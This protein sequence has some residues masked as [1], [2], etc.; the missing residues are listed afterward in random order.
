MQEFIGNIDTYL[1]GAPL[2]A[3]AA[4]FAAGLLTSFTPCVYPLI[5]VTVSVIGASSAGSRSRALYLSILYVLGLAA[6]YAGLGAFAALSGQLFG[7]I[8]TG[9]WTFLAVGNI[10]LLFGLAMLDV[11]SL[12]F[13]GLQKLSA[14]RRG[15]KGALSALFMGGVSALIAGPCTTPVL[16]TLLGFVA[17]RQNIVFGIAMLFVFSLGL[18]A[19][20]VLV[21]TFAGALAALPR[22]G[23]WMVMVKKIFGIVMII[24]G[25]IFILKAGQ[26]ML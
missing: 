10:F 20:L 26:L 25:E 3:L 17:L 13:M 6:V 11:F 24:I 15:S 18:G 22:S 5:P 2:L 12:Q 16:G 14:P 9:K 8:S 23:A 21:G 7:Q 19:L 4:A 1:Q